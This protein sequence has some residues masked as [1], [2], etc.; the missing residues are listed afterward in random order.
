MTLKGGK[1]RK[2]QRAIG[3]VGG[4]KIVLVEEFISGAPGV[5]EDSD[6]SDLLT[7]KM[8]ILDAPGKLVAEG[9]PVAL[10][11]KS[12][13]GT[14][15]IHHRKLWIVFARCLPI[16]SMSLSSP[17]QASYHL[18]SKDPVVVEKV[19]QLLHDEHKTLRVASYDVLGT[20]IEDIFLHLF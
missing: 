18:K 14:F 2:L 19:P 3:I 1:K 7:D 8:A 9:T 4:S 11:H 17:S 15:R 16:C 5:V 20:S 10:K 6:V 13:F 12:N